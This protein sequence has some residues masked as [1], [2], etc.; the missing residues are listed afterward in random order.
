MKNCSIIFMASIFCFSFWACKKEVKKVNPVSMELVHVFDQA[1]FRA[2]SSTLYELSDGT[3]VSF[4]NLRYYLS[5]IRLK[6]DQGQWWEEED[7][8][9]I[10]NASDRDISLSLDI[11]EGN[12][13]EIHYLIGV[14]SVKNFSGAQN[15]AL[16][17]SNGMFWSWQTGYIFLKSEGICPQINSS[18][19]FFIHHIGGFQSPN[20]AIQTVHHTLPQKL[21]I[22][23]GSNNKITLEVNVKNLYDRSEN[24]ISIP[25]L[26]NIHHPSSN[27]VRVSNNFPHMFSVRNIQN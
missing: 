9:H 24:R 16:S 22:K 5:N 7:S 15:G 8:Y 18:N 26:T 12:Y 10:I 6:N 2:D 11:P 20:N 23:S 13:T 1:A 21:E 4:Y 17:P 19:Q 27:A 25:N 3:Q 14:D